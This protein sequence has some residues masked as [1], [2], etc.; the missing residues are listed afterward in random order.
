MDSSLKFY[1]KQD[2]GKQFDNVIVLEGGQGNRL[3]EDV[4]T[5]FADG[6]LSTRTTVLPEELTFSLDTMEDP[7]IV[8]DDDVVRT[9][10]NTAD[11][12]PQSA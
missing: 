12:Y 11:F 1:C 5:I 3:T 2:L 6:C 8:K 4:G 10:A 9:R 7:I